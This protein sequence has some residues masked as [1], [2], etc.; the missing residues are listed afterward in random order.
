MRVRRRKDHHLVD[1]GIA[2]DPLQVAGRR[3]V[4][5]L[6]KGPAP[7]L[8]PAERMG[9]VD[10][11]LEVEQAPGVGGHGHAEADHGDAVSAHGD[12]VSPYGPEAALTTVGA[13]APAGWPRMGVAGPSA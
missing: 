2:R 9:D 12:G 6:G 5:A 4:E 7:R 8:A 13:P 10:P 1:R 11:I 3:K